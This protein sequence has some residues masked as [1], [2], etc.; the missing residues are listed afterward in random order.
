M[1][2]VF[3]IWNVYIMMS[4]IICD[5][6]HEHERKSYDLMGIYLHVNLTRD[7]LRWLVKT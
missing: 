5:P 7:Q 6:G 3:T 1:V 2:K 4:V